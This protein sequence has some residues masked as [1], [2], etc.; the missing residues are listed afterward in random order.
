M[1][2]NFKT[3]KPFLYDLTCGAITALLFSSFIYFEYFGITLKLLNTIFGILALG[4]FLYIPKRAVL[5]AGFLIGPIWFYWVG[6]SFEYTDAGYVSN[7]VTFIF[8]LIYAAF[9]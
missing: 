7:I 2:N 1:I 6:Y 4:M 9:F 8:G 5:I 3:N